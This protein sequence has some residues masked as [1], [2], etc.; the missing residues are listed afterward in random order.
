MRRARAIRESRKQ[1]PDHAYGEAFMLMTYACQD[2]GYSERIW[3]SRNG[4][5]PFYLACPKC[6]GWEKHVNWF[7]NDYQPEYQP[8]PGQRIF[9]GNAETPRVEVVK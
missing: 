6:A 3:N 8:M 9:T 1:S 7:D 5:T 2:C 4:V